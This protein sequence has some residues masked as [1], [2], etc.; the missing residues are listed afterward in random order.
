MKYLRILE[1][2]FSD[3]NDTGESSLHSVNVTNKLRLS[4]VYWVYMSP[5]PKKLVL[6]LFFL[7]CCHTIIFIF[8]V[9]LNNPTNMLPSGQNKKNI[10]YKIVGGGG[11]VG[12]FYWC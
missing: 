3:V 2:R 4:G 6:C 12:A 10:L 5:N 8:S 11:D 7:Y 1:E 9:N